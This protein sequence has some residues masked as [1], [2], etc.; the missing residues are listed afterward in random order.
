MIS[1]LTTLCILG[2]VMGKLVAISE[3]GQT[4]ED[5]VKAASSS[6][7]KSHEKGSIP[8]L[9]TYYLLWIDSQFMNMESASCLQLK[10]KKL[11]D[12]LYVVDISQM[13]EDMTSGFHLILGLEEFLG[14]AEEQPLAKANINVFG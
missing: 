2:G 6:F 12:S 7:Y 4:C 10:S 1:I 11:S 9:G 8:F 5:I 13:T 3:S 14:Q